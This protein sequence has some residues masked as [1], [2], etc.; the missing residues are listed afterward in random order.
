MGNLTRRTLVRNG[1]ALGAAGA[2]TGPALLEWARAW[3]Q[4]A[5]WQPE[6]GAQ[7]SLLRPTVFA[8]REGEA[9]VAATEAFTKA[10]GVKI[11]ISRESGD[12]IQPKASVAANT[13]A[14]PDLFVGFYSLP[15]LFPDKCLDVSDVA[16]YLG[17]KYGG[18]APSATAYGKGAGSKWINILLC[19]AGSL[20]NYR[21][22]SLRKAGF[23]KFPTTTAEFLDYARAMKSNNTPGGFALGHATNDASLW[24]YW[25]LWTHGGNLVD[26]NDK[27]IINSPETEKALIFAKQLYETMVPGVLSWNDASNNKAFL[28]GEIH[29]TDNTDSI[30]LAA[31]VDPSKKEI[32]ADMDHAYMPIGPIG[33]Q[34][35]LHIADVFFTMAYTKYPQAS[36]AL[37]AFMMEA[38]QYNRWLQTAQGNVSHTLNFYD[39]NPVWTEDPKWTVFRDAAKRTRTIG[40]LGSP[41]E[42]ASRAFF[43][44]ILVDMF[45][46]FCIGRE[47]TKG[48][49][50]TA[51]R[52]LQRIY[53]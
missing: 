36:K 24:V 7:L 18:W 23:S 10:T 29:W 25:C 3:A 15:H 8:P 12:D 2:L 14:G 42:K 51:E 20:M 33:M 34:T 11:T 31:K 30:Y 48:A 27:V 50:R 44:F 49:M 52:R 38:D 39:S 5:P 26:K 19:F 41:G 4:A 28:A 6:R 40:G 35:E 22:S 9:F 1:T 17:R 16:E 47:D 53:R 45:A 21:I 46:S 13:G 32:A 37:M 43:D